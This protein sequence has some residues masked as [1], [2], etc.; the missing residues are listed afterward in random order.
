MFYEQVTEA[1]GVPAVEKRPRQELPEQYRYQFRVTLMHAVTGEEQLIGF[2]LN[3]DSFCE[4]MNEIN[5]FRP[6]SIWGIVDSQCK[7]RAF[8]DADLF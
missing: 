1:F 2:E 3:S 8:N 6:S 4:V 7:D 5:R